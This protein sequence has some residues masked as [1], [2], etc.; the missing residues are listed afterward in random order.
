M[1]ALRRTFALNG[2]PKWTIF[3]LISK[4]R[5]YLMLWRES[6]L[7]WSEEKGANLLESNGA[8]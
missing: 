2:I 5:K 8:G 4:L 6:P 7:Q 1:L 3:L